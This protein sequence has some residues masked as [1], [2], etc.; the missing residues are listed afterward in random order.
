MKAIVTNS[1]TNINFSRVFSGQELERELTY[2]HDQLDIQRAEL[3]ELEHAHQ[4]RPYRRDFMVRMRGGYR[5]SVRD[6]H[7]QIENVRGMMH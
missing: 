4:A 6:L 5:T 3:R 1:A 2:L 7:S